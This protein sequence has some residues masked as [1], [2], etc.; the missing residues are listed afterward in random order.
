MRLL[1]VGALDPAWAARLAAPG[2]DIILLEGDEDRWSP[3]PE[4][5]DAVVAVGALDT[6][7]DLP[8]ALVA[9]RHALAPDRPFLGALFGG[10]SLPALRKLLIATDQ[11]FGGAAPRAHPRLDGPTLA[12]L[13]LAAG[14]ETPVV[15]VDR[16][17][18]S[19]RQP[20]RLI[21]DLRAS[22]A[23]NLLT[24]RPRTAGKAWSAQFAAQFERM[25]VGGRFAERVDLLHFLAWSPAGK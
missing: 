13:L 24:A 22:A 21:A 12:A 14:F 10:D 23:T 15:D 19:Y 5:F 2:R 7:N 16:M 20:D 8:R 9:L 4:P 25:K 1:L 11:A 18:L 6:V 17:K 3:P